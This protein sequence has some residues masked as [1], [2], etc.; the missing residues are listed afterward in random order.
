MM[1]AVNG[2]LRQGEPCIALEWWGSSR[3][4]EPALA[5]GQNEHRLFLRWFHSQADCAAA[6]GT[7]FRSAKTATCQAGSLRGLRIDRTITRA[8]EPEG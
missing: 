7:G 5:S 4:D 2:K 3:C 6:R 8:I 1:G